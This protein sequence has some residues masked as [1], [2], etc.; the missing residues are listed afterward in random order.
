MKA[1]K[2]TIELIEQ[3]IAEGIYYV[4]G[5]RPEIDEDQA[6]KEFQTDVLRY[7]R[8]RGW[9]GYH[10]YDSRRCEEGMPDWVFARDRIIFV[11]LKS[12]TGKLTLKQM[13]VIDRLRKAGG[14]VY[15]WQPVD[16]PRIEEVLNRRKP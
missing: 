12:M 16:W 2:A 5:M 10:T 6:E 3:R 14:E 1:D 8:Q 7:S 11:E 13:E 15:V 9:W 4:G